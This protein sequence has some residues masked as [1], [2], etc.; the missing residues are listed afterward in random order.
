[1]TVSLNK[2]SKQDLIRLII[3]QGKNIDTKNEKITVGNELIEL[4][5]RLIET[6]KREVS[7]YKASYCRSKTK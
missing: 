4:Q 2:L 1:M 6:L 3:N 5:Y 7:L